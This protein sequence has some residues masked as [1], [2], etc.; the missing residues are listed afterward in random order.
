MCP[1]TFTDTDHIHR[2]LYKKRGTAY[3]Y[4][5]GRVKI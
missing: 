2:E 4:R 3:V 1:V 5:W